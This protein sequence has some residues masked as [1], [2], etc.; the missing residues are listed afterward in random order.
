MLK[1][2]I[3]VP[4]ATFTPKIAPSWNFVYYCMLTHP[5]KLPCKFGIHTPTNDKVLANVKVLHFLSQNSPKNYRIWE[6][7]VLV[8]AHPFNAASMRVSSK[9]VKGLAN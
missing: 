8:H 4:N 2:F 6:F 3:F 9:S 1:F 7:G 5:M